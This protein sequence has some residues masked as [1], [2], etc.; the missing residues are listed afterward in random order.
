[1]VALSSFLPADFMNQINAAFDAWAQVA[2]ITFVQVPDGGGN[3]G[4]GSAATIRIGGGFIDGAGTPTRNVLGQA[5]LPPAGGNSQTRPL[6]GDIV[7]DS[8]EPQGTW[9][10][11]L[12]YDLTLHEIGHALGLEHENSALAVMNPIINPG[13][14]LQPD[15]IAGIR[16]IYGAST[17][18][19]TL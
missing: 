3:F 6:D 8:G 1:T 12:L 5:F 10:D 18:S 9:T 13:L 2:N 19:L 11:A 16:A 14:P 17:A 7:I 15:D 4:V